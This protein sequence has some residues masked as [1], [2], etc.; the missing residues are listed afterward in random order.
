MAIKNYLYPGYRKRLKSIYGHTR[1]MNMYTSHQ[2]LPIRMQ[3]QQ[4]TPIS[5][6][7]A[8]FGPHEDEKSIL[9]EQDIERDH[10]NLGGKSSDP[11]NRARDGLARHTLQ[12]GLFGIELSSSLREIRF[13]DQE[14]AAGIFIFNIKYNHSVFQN[15]NSL[16]LF[17][18]QLD[19]GL[20]KYFT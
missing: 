13:S 5:G 8:N 17:H 7:K 14:F 10:K 1:H 15:D 4:N 2:V 19:Y 16:Y 3:P 6:K 18:D 9:Q 11:E 12:T 20:A